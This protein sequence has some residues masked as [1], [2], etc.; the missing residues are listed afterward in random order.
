[1]STAKTVVRDVVAV[2]V[3]AALAI[4]VDHYVS[5]E[6]AWTAVLAGCAALVW[7]HELHKPV[8]AWLIAFV[9]N[10]RSLVIVLVVMILGAAALA[11]FVRR[12]GGVPAPKSAHLPTVENWAAKQKV[13]TD[14][15]IPATKRPS[16]AQ[17]QFSFFTLGPKEFPILETTMPLVNGF[18]DLDIIALGKGTI[19]AK[20][21]WLTLIIC[22]ECRYATEPPNMVAVPS[23][24]VMSKIT[25][26]MR[27]EE[28]Y[29]GTI[30]WEMKLKII[31]PP[32]PYDKAFLIA[33]RY[34]CDN[35]PPEDPARQ[36][37]LRVNV[38]VP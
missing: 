13:K 32:A 26:H 2:L 25:R 18:V 27:F 14:V 19:P 1:M 23:D 5:V 12:F 9:G 22:N 38:R 31:P 34:V 36:Q 10:H 17:L 15:P 11:V 21:G 16:T 3:T 33:G 24:N 28:I 37:V 35:C 7:L 6:L 29:P 8:G 20:N 4:L 30:S